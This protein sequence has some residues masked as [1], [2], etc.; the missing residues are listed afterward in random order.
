MNAEPKPLRREIAAGFRDMLDSILVP[1]RSVKPRY[2]PLMTIYFAQGA[3]GLTA[4]AQ[5]FWV[6]HE[7]DLS[8]EALVALTI[9]LTVPWTIKMVVGQMVDCVPIIG[10]R[11][12]GYIFLGAGLI[13]SS[14]LLLAGAASGTLKFASP[15]VLYIAASL[16]G[17]IG[18][19]V[20][21]VVADTMTTEVVDRHEP[22]GTWRP[23]KDVDADL[24]MVQVLGRL[25]LLAGGFVTAGLGGWLAQAFVAETVFLIA[26]AIPALA[27]TGAL[28]VRPHA[29]DSSEIDWRILGGGLAFGLCVVT[30]GILQ[31]P[32][33]QELTVF[34]SLLIVV[35]LLRI[36]VADI[37]PEWQKAIMYAAILILVYRAR[38][39][40]GPG[41]D[42][43]QIDELRFDPAFFG[44]LAQIGAGLSIAGLWYFGK[45]ITRS[46]VSK[47]LFWLIIIQA[48]MALPNIGL[49]YGLHEWTEK[50]FGFGART[51][52]IIDQAAESPFD[53]LAT[54]PMLTLIAIHAPPG[55]RATWF[56]LMASL[57]NI[58][59]QSGRMGSKY[60]NQIFVVERGDYEVLGELMISATVISLVVPM[61]AILLIGRRVQSPVR[62]D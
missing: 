52:A 29:S 8:A 20:Q 21:D 39:Q 59:L 19:V 18:I 17:V 55:K 25:S 1:I 10:S 51:I 56:A 49:Y 30:M 6:K 36:T 27:V 16:I 2:L 24:G 23:K 13:A 54:I 11:R 32:F 9:W 4:I 33:A 22:D 7:L 60:L 14:L 34:V 40:A 50:M 58:A 42:W 12:R 45:I 62:H 35:V 41:V 44:T 61:A 38:P 46:P 53:H 15:E 31:M 47:V 43:W 57:M 48:V 26:L 28:L 5:T 37:D 3:A